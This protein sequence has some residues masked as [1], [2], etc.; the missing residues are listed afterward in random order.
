MAKY[1]AVLEQGDDGSWSAY[2]LA[3]SLVIGT[4]TTKDEALADLK[5]AMS[6][7]LEYMKD[8]G[9]AIPPVSTEVV[10]FEIAA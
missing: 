8:S 4:G 9:Q 10:S 5:V 7:W 2:T 3:P 1:T 6:F